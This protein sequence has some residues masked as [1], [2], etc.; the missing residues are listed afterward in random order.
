[1]Q[2]VRCLLGAVALLA[3]AGV[4]VAS[5][6]PRDVL[7]GEVG[8]VLVPVAGQRAARPQ[9]AEV[10]PDSAESARRKRAVRD[11]HKKYQRL[12]HS[13]HVQSDIRYRSVSSST[14][15]AVHLRKWLSFPCSFLA[16]LFP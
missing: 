13:V 4:A 3:L 15:A 2:G 14:E 8:L 6:S 10:I 9:E 11:G 16:E 5:P 1:M 12:A 7:R